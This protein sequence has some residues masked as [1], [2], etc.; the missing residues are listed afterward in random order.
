MICEIGEEIIIQD[1]PR[2]LRDKLRH[3]LTFANPDYIKKERMGLW[4]GNTPRH[5]SLMWERGNQIGVPFGLYDFLIRRNKTVFSQI[6]DRVNHPINRVDYGCSIEPYDYQQEAITSA[7]QAGNGILVAPCGSGKTQMGLAIAAKIGGRTL[8]LTHTSELLNQSM[9]RA[10]SIYDLPAS[11]YGTITEGKIN[12]GSVITFATVQT[13]SKMN[14]SIVRDAFDTVIVDEAHHCV[15]T[16]AK[17]QMFYKVVSGLRC[18]YKYGLTATPNR[19]DGMIACMYALIGGKVYTVTQ[20]QVAKNLCPVEVHCRQTGFTPDMSVVLGS[21]GTLQYSALIDNIVNSKER[22]AMIVRDVT[23]RESQGE[24]NL[25]LTDRVAHA[26]ELTRLLGAENCKILTGKIT[27]KER[28]SV[29]AD[30]MEGK[31]NTVVATYALAQEGLDL[32]CLDNVFF[33]T[34]KKDSTAVT[35]SAGRVA[36]KFEGKQKGNVYDYVDSFGMLAGWW[37]KR[38]GVYKKSGYTIALPTEI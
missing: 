25:V 36:R 14:L 31:I 15:G 35:Q 27:K 29:L 16:P 21:D 6:V 20:N 1:P 11:D 3:T 9:E 30:L 8:W 33:A 26:K 28:K 32:P 7:L 22:N 23:T 17:V 18:R 4:T 37:R 24:K 38:C 34:P 12:I 19:S 2:E 13:M 10:Q 5:L